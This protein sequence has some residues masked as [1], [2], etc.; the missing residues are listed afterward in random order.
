MADLTIT[1]ASVVPSANATKVT[2]NAAAGVTI[3]AGQLVY[4]D[5]NTLKLTDNDA[6][7]AAAKVAGIAVCGASPGQPCTYVTKDPKL[8]I[9]A[10]VSIGAVYTNSGTPGGIAPI[11]DKATGDFIV[12]VAVGV[13]TTQVNFDVNMTASVDDVLV[14]V[15]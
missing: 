9:G 6:S 13:S 14:A 1:A 4:L 11:G 12:V 7:A 5:S 3:T 10:T 8:A 15:P 2:R